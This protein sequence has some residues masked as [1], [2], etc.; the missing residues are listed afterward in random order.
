MSRWQTL[1]GALARVGSV[2]P[3]LRTLAVPFGAVRA[4]FLS[5]HPHH[6]GGTELEEEVQRP[7]LSP[8][9]LGKPTEATATS[10]REANR[11]VYSARICPHPQADLLYV[12]ESLSAALLPASALYRVRRTT[13]RWRE[14]LG[15]VVRSV[16]LHTCADSITTVK[17]TPRE[18][19]SS[20]V[21]TEAVQLRISK[22]KGQALLCGAC[23][24]VLT[25][26]SLLDA[27]ME[28]GES[29]G[30][31]NHADEMA[32]VLLMYPTPNT[33]RLRHLLLSAYR[34]E[35]T[36]L[37]GCPDTGV[38]KVNTNEPTSSAADQ[39]EPRPAKQ[40]RAFFLANRQLAHARETQDR[41]RLLA[42]ARA[43]AVSAA[44][45]SSCSHPSL[46][47]QTCSIY[48]EAPVLLGRWWTAT[49]LFCGLTLA[50]FVSLRLF[51][52][53]RLQRDHINPAGGLQ[54]VGLESRG[55]GDQPAAVK[56]VDVFLTDCERDWC[57]QRPTYYVEVRALACFVSPPV[58]SPLCD[59]CSSGDSVAF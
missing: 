30:C 53:A 42:Q 13:A 34:A 41:E 27:V 12:K 33:L 38:A 15:S 22:P 45:T 49:L 18:L 25:L 28:R 21:V 7:S 19:R 11:S 37:A 8:T 17:S 56:D 51:L 44:A 40:P 46:L 24:A 54:R 9:T 6:D 52:L 48:A 4:L 58:A 20:K 29:R 23:E 50:D 31:G 39:A 43:R 36:W 47:R 57:V 14:L 10:T 5:Y 26:H 55:G 32:R 1:I 2:L 35:V 59:G 16:L 3:H